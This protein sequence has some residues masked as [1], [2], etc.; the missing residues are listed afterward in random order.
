MQ[1]RQ[2]LVLRY[3][4][5]SDRIE[6]SSLEAKALKQWLRRLVEME[7]ALISTPGSECS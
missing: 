2:N 1:G 4:E 5:R 3:V 7:R 6:R